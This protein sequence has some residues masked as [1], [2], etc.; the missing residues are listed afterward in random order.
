MR[1]RDVIDG[2]GLGLFYVG[3]FAFLSAVPVL[4]RHF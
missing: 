3:A 1:W 2:L 4:A